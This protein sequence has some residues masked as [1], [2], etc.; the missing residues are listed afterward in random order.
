VYDPPSPT[1]GKR[2]LVDRLW[3]RGVS[4]STLRIDGW[5]KDVAPS[6]AL[7]R[8]FGHDPRRWDEF[9]RRYS[10]ELDARPQAWAPLL[11]AAREGPVTLLFSARD[12]A[13]NNAVALRAYLLQR[14]AASRR[15]TPR[16]RSSPR[17]RA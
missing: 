7:R 10:A 9:V 4:A 1:D 5:L 17:R 3:P 15:P 11:Q 13:H 6:D 14:L 12:T 16:G 2:F 8:W